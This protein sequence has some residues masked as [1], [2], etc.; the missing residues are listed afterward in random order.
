MQKLIS[1]G[2]TEQDINEYRNA[3]HMFD[4]NNTGVISGETLKTFY[5]QFGETFQDEDVKT[6]VTEFTGDPKANQINFTNFALNF[7]AKK[8]TWLGAFGD[9]FDLIDK[10]GTG[11][12]EVNRLKEVMKLLGEDLTDA[13][14]TAMIKQCGTRD[15]FMANLSSIATGGVGT[16]PPV[17]SGMS[18]M[19]SATPRGGFGLPPPMPGRGPA[20]MPPPLPGMGRPPRAGL[21]AGIQGARGGA[22]RPPPPMPGMGARGGAPPR[23]PPPM[24]GMG[25]RPPP[26]PGGMRPPPPLPPPQ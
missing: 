7:H 10:D 18:M 12:L 24:P 1:A 23:P 22:P 17:S 13:E 4:K 9:A 16:V 25:A 19:P 5:A 2:L 26:P 6:M 3:F 20:R 21:L 11:K 8:H 14:A 15:S